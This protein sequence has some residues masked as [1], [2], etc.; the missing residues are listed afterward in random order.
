MSRKIKFRFFD[1]AISKMSKSQSL[2]MLDNDRYIPMQ[3][4]GLYDKNGVEIY[5]GDIIARAF[6][7]YNEPCEVCYIS[8]ILSLRTNKSKIHRVMNIEKYGWCGFCSIDKGSPNYEFRV[9]GNI[10]ENKEIKND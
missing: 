9:I 10:Y 5:E 4:I 6:D 1:N 7:D 2:L 3:F 8:G